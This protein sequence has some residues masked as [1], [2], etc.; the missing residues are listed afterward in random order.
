MAD[1]Q[2][3]GG[4]GWPTPPDSGGKSKTDEKCFP[5]SNLALLSGAQN[6]SKK[7]KKGKKG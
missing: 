5:F 3:S 2:K 6:F 7:G 1:P 4:S